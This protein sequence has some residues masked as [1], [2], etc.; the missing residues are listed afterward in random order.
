MFCGVGNRGV[1]HQ[2]DDRLVADI[3]DAEANTGRIE[4]NKLNRTTC[5]RSGPGTYPL[6]PGA[7][8]KESMINTA[9]NC[10]IKVALDGKC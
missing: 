1:E 5:R 9:A 4:S 2:A 3:S 10:R 7:D 8:A 6:A